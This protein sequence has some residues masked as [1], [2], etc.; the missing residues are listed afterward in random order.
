MTEYWLDM[1]IIANMDFITESL[2][3]TTEENVFS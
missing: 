2:A 3:Y 1:R